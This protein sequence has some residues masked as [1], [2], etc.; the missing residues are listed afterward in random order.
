MSIGKQ[1]FL[2]SGHQ[3]PNV[4]HFNGCTNKGSLGNRSDRMAI[5][6][7]WDSAL[8]RGS[9]FWMASQQTLVDYQREP[10]PVTDTHGTVRSFIETKIARAQ[11]TII[12]ANVRKVKANKPSPLI[13]YILAW[14]I[15]SAL[16]ARD[17]HTYFHQLQTSKA[18]T[19]MGNSR[20]KTTSTRSH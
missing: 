2:A 18:K 6:D 13:L 14:S 19:R 4:V 1:S 11:N 5:S 3:E 16:D 17:N 10:S 9:L 12:T 8:A 15:S 7:N 20:S